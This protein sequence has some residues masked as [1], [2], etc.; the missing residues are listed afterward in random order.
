MT[1]YDRWG[2]QIFET[3]DMNA[4]W[5]AGKYPNGQYIVILEIHDVL[6]EI[7]HEKG[8]VSITR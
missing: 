4:G 8:V 7:H 3:L 1:I 2:S 5:D 6:G